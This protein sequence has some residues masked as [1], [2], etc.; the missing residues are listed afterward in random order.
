MVDG[1]PQAY[2]GAA[3]AAEVAHGVKQQQGAAVVRSP[4]P[5]DQRVAG[6]SHESMAQ[7]DH[8]G[9]EAGPRQASRAC[10]QRQI[11][12]AGELSVTLAV[13]TTCGS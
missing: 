9:R 13:V 6:D 8:E 10:T 3:T 1:G 12:A 11:G 7:G 2:C 4:W 5:R